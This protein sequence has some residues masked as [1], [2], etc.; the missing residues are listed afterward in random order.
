MTHRALANAL[1]RIRQYGLAQRS[2]YPVSESLRRAQR[3]VSDRLG[4]IAKVELQHMRSDEP[5]VY[6]AHASPPLFYQ[7]SQTCLEHHGFG[8]SAIPE[9]ALIKAIGECIER[10][11]AFPPDYR[12]LAFGS[13]ATVSQICKAVALG[14]FA[15]FSQDQYADSALPF[16][17]PACERPMHWVKG[18]SLTS[19][20]PVLVPASFVFVPYD[21]MIT[22]YPPE[23]RF[24]TPIST[25]LACGPTYSSA[26]YRGLLEVIERDAFMLSWRH[27]RSMPTLDIRQ[28]NGALTQSLMR[29]VGEIPVS[30]VAKLATVDISVSVVL[31]MLTATTRRFPLFAMGAGTDFDTEQALVLAL[32]EALQ[33]YTGLSRVESPHDVDE[34]AE[35]ARGVNTVALNGLAHA[36]DTSLHA[37]RRCLVE[38][39][40][41]AAPAQTARREGTLG[42]LVQE[43][44]E[45]GHEAIAVDLTP[46]DIDEAGFKV[47]RV[48]VPGLQPL[49]IDQ[50]WPYLGSARSE[51]MFQS[52]DGEPVTQA[53]SLP[54][55][56]PHPFA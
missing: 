8:M 55:R 17:H 2:E 13:H 38:P 29:A 40:A 34:I 20:D 46:A 9:R 43:L 33:C 48:L 49:D 3:L 16:E 35:R 22:S 31:V 10:Y 44:S 5:Q 53:N 6:W 23:P 37:T 1:H 51:A 27:E 45:K 30:C 14:R 12:T 52:L 36:R 56:M 18:I 39:T 54:N 7:G 41:F 32:E 28:F 25:G 50:N 26:V 15:L 42:D 11:C 19:G 21:S 24:A 47:V 4:I